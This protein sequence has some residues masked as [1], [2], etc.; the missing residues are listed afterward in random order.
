MCNNE[1]W[2]P[3][4]GYEGLYE[5]SNLGNV[6]SV[7]RYVK[8]NWGNSFKVVRERILKQT[9]NTYGYPSVSLSKDN[10][11]KT[12]PVHILVCKAFVDNPDNL[13]QVNHINE[14]K[15]DNR[16]ENLEWCSLQYNIN[17]GTRTE[18]MSLTQSVPIYSVDTTTNDIVFYSSISSAAKQVNTTSS[19]ICKCLLG[20]CNT[21]R[22]KKWFYI[23]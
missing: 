1:I 19:N 8:H 6:K 5:V 12:F 18:R 2:K 4:N 16:A 17:Y 3:I 7:E 10:K 22:G 15:T 13:E 14:D 21:I 20:R 11:K 9:C 23:N